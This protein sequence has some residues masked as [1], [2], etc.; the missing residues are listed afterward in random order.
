MRLFILV[1]SICLYLSANDSLTSRIKTCAHKKD[2]NAKYDNCEIEY[3]P[4]FVMKN[5]D[6]AF[7]K[8]YQSCYSMQNSKAKIHTF[9]IYNPTPKR[10]HIYPTMKPILSFGDTNADFFILHIDNDKKP[11][12]SPK[13][14]YFTYSNKQDKSIS[15]I[16]GAKVSKTHK[17]FLYFIDALDDEELATLQNYT[18]S[19]IFEAE[20]QGFFKA[21]WFFGD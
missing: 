15:S 19:I 21:D 2:Y 17:K 16:L 18:I 20:G 4:E 13:C 8:N 6:L 10:T 7:Q 9:W 11:R 3:V 5:G 1:L 12:I 14:A